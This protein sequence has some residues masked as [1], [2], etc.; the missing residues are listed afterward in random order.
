MYEDNDLWPIK[1]PECGEEFTKE[2]GWLKAHTEVRCPGVLNALG[3]ILCPVTI[4][5]GTEQLGLDIAEAK[6]GRLDPFGTYWTRK[7]RP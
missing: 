2:V 7:V 4:T 1:C 5:Y 3:P 6:A